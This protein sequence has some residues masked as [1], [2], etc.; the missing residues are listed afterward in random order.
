MLKTHRNVL[1]HYER[2]W[3]KAH[4]LHR[5]PGR[6]QK[7]HPAFVIAEFAPRAA[8][9]HWTYATCGMSEHPD[10]RLELHIF[11]N[12]QAKSL[13]MLLTAVADF[14]LTGTPLGLHHSVNFGIPWLPGSACTRGFVSL[15]YL[16]GPKLETQ[17]DEAG[18]IRHLW[19]IP[20]TEREL[21][22]RRAEGTE[23][24][25]ARFEEAQ[26]DYASATRGSVV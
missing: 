8:R 13:V 16:G 14:H 24:L 20:V 7:T 6:M 22:F 21:A 2:Q 17:E 5:D 3:G 25:E 23:A 12:E 19:L 15:P 1:A 18:E 10:A 11:S 4:A 26:F 9:P